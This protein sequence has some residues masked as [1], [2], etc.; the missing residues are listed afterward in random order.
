MSVSMAGDLVAALGDRCD[1]LGVRACG[2]P[3][4][5]EGRADTELIQQREHRRGLAPERR[6]R[7][8]G[9]AGAEAAAHE[10]VPILVV[11]AQQQRSRALERL[12]YKKFRHPWP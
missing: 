3:E 10:L 5:E 12:R 8:L 7:P 1:Q 6:A 4:Y 9:G 2:H 11:D